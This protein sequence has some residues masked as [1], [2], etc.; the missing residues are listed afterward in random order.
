M[1][2]IL[3]TAQFGLDYG[4]SNSSGKVSDDDKFICNDVKKD[5]KNM[6]KIYFD[7]FKE[8]IEQDI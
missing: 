2:Y 5:L 3:G 6:K 7:T 1:E 8:V 4:V